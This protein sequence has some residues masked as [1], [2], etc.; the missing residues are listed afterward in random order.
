M[1]FQMIRQEAFH[2][3]GRLRKVFTKDGSNL[4]DI[5]DFWQECHE[6]G[7]S[8]KLE[9]LSE[10][11]DMFGICMDF[12]GQGGFHYMIGVRTKGTPGESDTFVTRVIPA[13]D[14]AVFASTGPMPG[15]IQQLW[16]H[17]YEE[18]FPSSGYAHAQGPEME[19]Y[20][21][22]DTMRDD[23]RCEVWIPVTKKP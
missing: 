3:T 2:V 4:R 10:D 9:A 12:D 21:P 18:W 13:A 7:T 1:E 19:V 14:W 8:M 6:D 23:Y 22:G 17:I 16:Q 5:P 20:P 11:K 15:A